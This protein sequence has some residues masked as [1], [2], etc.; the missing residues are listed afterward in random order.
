[1]EE[2]A[3]AIARIIATAVV[4]VNAIL[5]ASGHSPIPVDE[6]AIY[7]TVSNIAAAISILWVWWKNNNV[8]QAAID[9][10]TAGTDVIHYD[11]EVCADDVREVREDEVHE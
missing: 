8:T 2:R 3:K 4:C 1:M 10:A 9:K 11:D 5:A 6:G 7:E